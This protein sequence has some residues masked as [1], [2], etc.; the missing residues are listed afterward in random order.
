[1]RNLNN[2]FGV[3]G[4]CRV[5]P[6]LKVH[7]TTIHFC[8]LSLFLYS[9]KINVKLSKLIEIDIFLSIQVSLDKLKRRNL[10]VYKLSQVRNDKI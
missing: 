3:M 9:Y 4:I 2:L 1:M 5:T 10:N 8:V 6:F 7:Y